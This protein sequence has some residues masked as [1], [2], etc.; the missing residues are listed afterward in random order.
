MANLTRA[1]ITRRYRE[2]HPE[3]AKENRRRWVEK[4]KEK[5]AAYNKERRRLGLTTQYTPSERAANWRKTKYG[6]TLKAYAALLF[7]QEGRCAL[8]EGAL[9]GRLDPVVDHC[10][11]TNRVRGLLCFSCNCALGKLG[12]TVDRI[13]QVLHYVTPR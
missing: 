3:K 10:H 4:N 7:S 13:K 11:Q 9:T 5:I 6:L 1:E 8:C 2:R 12:D